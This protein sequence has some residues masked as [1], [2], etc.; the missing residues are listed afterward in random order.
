MKYHFDFDSMKGASNTRIKEMFTDI[1]NKWFLKWRDKVT[2]ESVLNAAYMDGTAIME[3]YPEEFALALF[4]GLLKAL[5]GRA[6]V[7]G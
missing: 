4:M 2:D 5:E 3:Q 7:N 1:Y 6:G